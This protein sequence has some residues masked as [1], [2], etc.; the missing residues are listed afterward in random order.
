MDETLLL[1]NDH[2]Q[3]FDF[4]LDV[5]GIDAK[6]A[7]VRFVIDDNGV[8]HSFACEQKEENVYSVYV[9][10]LPF[11]EKKTYP[12]KI[13]VII[14]G[15]FFTPMTG[16]V[17][18]AERPQVTITPV[19]EPTQPTEEPTIVEPKKTPE[20]KQRALDDLLQAIKPSVETVPEEIQSPIVNVPEESA[21]AS[22]VPQQPVS[23]KDLKVKKALEDLKA[24]TL[25][26]IT[27][28]AEQTAALPNTPT[29]NLQINELLE[30]E[31]RVREILDSVHTK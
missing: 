1:N 13:E 23:E 9:P 19:T 24:R 15:Y 20:Q 4:K 25:S 10:A 21:L 16:S 12:C 7:G 29:R 22:V 30:K 11:L 3:T 31:R 27:S 8:F 6:D 26:V 14:D 28:V 17:L 18:V 2:P 5:E